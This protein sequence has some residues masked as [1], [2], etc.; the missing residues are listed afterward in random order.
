MNATTDKTESVTTAKSPNPKSVKFTADK[1]ASEKAEAKKWLRVGKVKERAPEPIKSPKPP[2]HKLNFK[3]SSSRDEAV[4]YF[5]AIIDGIKKGSI[6]F[7]QEG[8]S[9]MLHPARD[10]SLEIKASAKGDN[11]KVTFKISWIKPSFIE[12]KLEIK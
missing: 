9:L 4:T 6:E 12:P 5:Q 1:S 7:K 10:L 8:E 11:E 3:K 2:R